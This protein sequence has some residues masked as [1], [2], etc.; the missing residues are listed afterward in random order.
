MTTSFKTEDTLLELQPGAAAL[1]AA[2]RDELQASAALKQRMAEQ[3]E[4]VL[5]AAL[6]CARALRA[7]RKVLFCGN[8][9]SAADALHLAAEFVGRYRL[10]R[11]ALPA[12][13]LSANIAVITAVGNDY[14]YQRVFARQVEALG[15]GGD[16]LVCLSTS[17][18]SANVF[19]AIEVARRR[20]LRVVAFTGTNGTALAGAADVA[21]QVPSTDTARVQE[22]YMTA[23]HAMCGIVERLLC[24]DLRD[25]PLPG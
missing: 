7:G 14:E 6:E 20:Q 12:I 9:G 4:P 5:R 19:K 11:E 16:V 21:L 13:A 3:P 18:T 22:G 2:I 10:E 8:G 17:G 24:G 15:N 25:Q 1:L 23:A